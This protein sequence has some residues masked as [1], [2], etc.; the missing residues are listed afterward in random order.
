MTTFNLTCEAVDATLADYLDETLEPWVR[1]SI[2]EHLDECARCAGRARALRNLEREAAVLPALVPERDLWPEVAH[3]IWATAITS[4]STPQ[5]EP[6]MASSEPPVLAS[7]PL[8]LIEPSLPTSELA[9]PTS[10]LA[11]PTSQPSLPTSESP[12]PVSEPLLPSAEAPLSTIEPAIALAERRE[13]RW[14]PAWMGLAAAAL[15]L[16]T[17][18]TTFLLTVRRFGPAQTPHVVT[19]TVTRRLSS[20]VTPSAP[21]GIRAPSVGRQQIASDSSAPT[22]SQVTRSPDEVVYDKEI[23]MLETMTRRRKSELDTSTA[24]VIERNLRI[25]DSNIAQIRAALQKD[26]GSPLLGDQ[27]SRALDMKVELLR[28]VALLRS[29]T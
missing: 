2:D 19:D 11:L 26:P 29:N 17:A 1:K 10:E 22:R 6:L 25:I 5:S 3:G 18:G 9:F 24:A 16:V 12:V 13:K 7:A 20:S 21:R 14:E 4:E 23:K 8:P 28:R 15:V 27:V